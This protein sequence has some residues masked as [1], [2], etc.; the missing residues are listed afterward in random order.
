LPD[1]SPSFPS[2]PAALRIY[3]IIPMQDPLKQ[4]LKHGNSLSSVDLI[5]SSIEGIIYTTTTFAVEVEM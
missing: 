5:E 1:Q 4:G 2:E 3:R